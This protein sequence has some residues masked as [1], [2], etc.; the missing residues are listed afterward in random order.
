MFSFFIMSTHK[1][2][3]LPVRFATFCYG[4]KFDDNVS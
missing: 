4:L 2:T 1:L 3:D